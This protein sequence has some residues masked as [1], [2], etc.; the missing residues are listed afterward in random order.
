MKIVRQYLVAHN[1]GGGGHIMN[2]H[3]THLSY[4]VAHNPSQA[5]LQGTG[6]SIR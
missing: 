2:Q 4:Q 1:W 5:G 3:G 6:K